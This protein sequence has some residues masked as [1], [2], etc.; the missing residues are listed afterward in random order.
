M[1]LV[2]IFMTLVASVILAAYVTYKMN[3]SRDLRWFMGK[4]AEELYCSAEAIDREVSKYF[5][6]K[7][8]FSAICGEKLENEQ[9]ALI[10]IGGELVNSKMLIGFY[11]QS[12]SPAL[13]RTI[14]AVATALTSLQHWE[15]ADPKEREAFLERLD[16]DVAGLKDALEAFKT[17]I[18][19]A[20]RPAA[21]RASLALF[22]RPSQVQ[23]GRVL[24]VAA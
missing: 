5:G 18:I 2:S 13:A 15:K 14:A 23:N 8:S 17:A 3:E 19:G 21:L 11:F 20:G 22:R 6:S 12:L 1:E 24:R 4:K 16:K 7:Y 9:E 10:K